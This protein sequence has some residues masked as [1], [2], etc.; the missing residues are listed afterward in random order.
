MAAPKANGGGAGPKDNKGKNDTIARVTG[1]VIVTGVAY[2]LYKYFAGDSDRPLGQRPKMSTEP[3]HEQISLE[4]PEAY[5]KFENRVKGAA[6]TLKEKA[7]EIKGVIEDK[8]R[9]I[10]R[11]VKGK[12]QEVKEWTV[13]KGERVRDGTADV[14]NRKGDEATSDAEDGTNYVAQKAEDSKNTIA[15]KAAD[16]KDFVADKVGKT[17]ETGFGWFGRGSSE[18]NKAKEEAKKFASDKDRKANDA[19]DRAKEEANREKEEAKRFA[20]DKERKVKD[21][22]SSFLDNVGSEANREKG[23][24]KRFGNE[25]EQK[26]EQAGSTVAHKASDLAHKVLPGKGQYKSGWPKSS[27][28]G[29]AGGD[30]GILKGD[31]LWSISRRFGVTIDEIKAANGIR[32]ADFIVAGDTITIPN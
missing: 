17:K 11:A 29:G 23:A 12:S 31:T 7:G 16:A 4:K 8:G 21:A 13:D 10:S 24:L 3:F 6:G 5:E 15:D 1:A 25:A 14:L 30:Y 28:R 20:G 18:A 27:G 22:G 9:G 19:Y 26:V 32:D 2:G